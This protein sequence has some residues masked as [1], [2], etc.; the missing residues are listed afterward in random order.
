MGLSES[1]LKIEAR[2]MFRPNGL[3]DDFLVYGK[4]EDYIH[5]SK[6]VVSVISSKNP[7][8][9]STDSEISIEISIDEN[10]TELFT[11]LQNK[12]HDYFSMGMWKA[13]NILRFMGN[14]NIL[15]S[16]HMFLINLSQRGEA[17]SY[18]SE[19]STIEKYSKQSPEW[20]LHL[21]I[22]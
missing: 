19:Y 14:E 16:L 3:I 17:Y 15:E 22:T 7:I 2:E 11:S 10:R 12:E 8:M 20:R 1:M 5:L 4:P 13:R 18:I 9:V 21:E 6:Q